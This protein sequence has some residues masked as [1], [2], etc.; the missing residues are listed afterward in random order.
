M[1]DTTLIPTDTLQDDGLSFRASG[2]LA[3]MLSF[4]DDHEHDVPSLV[5]DGKEGREAVRATLRELEAAGHIAWRLV[6]V[7]QSN[8]GALT[9]QVLDV[10]DTRGSA[11]PSE[12]RRRPVPAVEW[13]PGDQL[14]GT[15]ADLTSVPATGFAVYRLYGHDGVLLY[16]GRSTHPRAR[17][18]AHLGL[19]GPGLLARWE[20][21]AYGAHDEMCRTEIDLIARLD[22]PLNRGGRA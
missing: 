12:T 7:E 22:P 14:F 8:G 5:R 20:M 19:R 17:L 21:T 9:R 6:R 10:Y 2:L 4:P 3:Y 11:P 1:T 13:R 15:F 16:I 18:K